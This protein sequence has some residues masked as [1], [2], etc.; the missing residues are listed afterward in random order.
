MT[1]RVRKAIRLLSIRSINHRTHAILAIFDSIT[2]R[3]RTLTVIRLFHYKVSLLWSFSPK[4][5]TFVLDQRTLRF[6]VAWIL[7]VKM[8]ERLVQL[9]FGHSLLNLRKPALTHQLLVP[10][11]STF[12]SVTDHASQHLLNTQDM[13]IKNAHHFTV[14]RER[15]LVSCNYLAKRRKHLLE[16]VLE[17]F[18]CLIDR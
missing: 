5:K 11:R 15:K 14:F 16:Q 12:H 9:L 10:P 1:K 6:V 18:K 3:Q 8:S 17:T 7:P 13:T 4:L 2:H